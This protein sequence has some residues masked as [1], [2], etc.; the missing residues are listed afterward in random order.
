MGKFFTLWGEKQSIL[1]HWEPTGF[2]PLFLLIPTLFKHDWQLLL[3]ASCSH[4]GIHFYLCVLDVKVRPWTNIKHLDKCV[5]VC[6]QAP[7]LSTNPKIQAC[8][9][10]GSSADDLLVVKH[11][12]RQGL[13]SLKGHWWGQGHR[14]AADLFK[15]TALMIYSDSLLK[16]TLQ[17]CNQ[18]IINTA[19]TKTNNR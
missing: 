18:R 1:E 7:V 4:P 11:F 15:S 16:L 9:C 10:L 2:S 5:C 12:K 14:V 17:W 13:F 19:I 8:L 6:V 3:W